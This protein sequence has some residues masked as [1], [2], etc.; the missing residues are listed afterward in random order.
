MLI[1][2]LYAHRPVQFHSLQFPILLPLSSRIRIEAEDIE[3][4]PLRLV[5]DGATLEGVQ[6]VEIRDSGRPVKLLRPADYEFIDTLVHKII[7]RHNSTGE[8]PRGGR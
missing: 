1:T 7:G 3:K 2:P 5:A 6:A 8:G 4:R